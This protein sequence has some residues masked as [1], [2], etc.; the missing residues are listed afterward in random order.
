MDPAIDFQPESLKDSRLYLQIIFFL[1]RRK[2]KVS[3]PLFHQLLHQI[4]LQTVI[5]I[6]TLLQKLLH[7]AFRFLPFN[8]T[9]FQLSE[10]RIQF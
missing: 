4:H 7:I 10:R 3:C 1:Q 8:N 5:I 6:F 2:G 9:L